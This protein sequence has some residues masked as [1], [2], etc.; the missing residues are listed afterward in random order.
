MRAASFAMSMANADVNSAM[1]LRDGNAAARHRLRRLHDG[2]L[3][4]LGERAVLAH[5]AA[6]DEPRHAVADEA[7]HDA[8]GGVD[9]ERQIGPELGGDGGE[10]AF[11]GDVLAHGGLLQSGTS[12]G[13][14]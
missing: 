9:V 1:P 12:S 14:D 11:P 4:G 10:D 2:D 5:G 3:L 13:L 6:D 8:R 7:F